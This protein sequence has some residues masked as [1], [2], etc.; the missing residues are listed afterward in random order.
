M[1]D[2]NDPPIPPGAPALSSD[3]PP[4]AQTA[5][6][7]STSLMD[8]LAKFG[9]DKTDLETRIEALLSAYPDL[10]GPVGPLLE[11]VKNAFTENV[12]VNMAQE[13]VAELVSVLKTRK[14]PAD[15]NDV[16]L[17]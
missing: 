1:T 7:L 11:A 2:P 4:Q 13:V 16:D 3:A 5:F 14:A 9:L 10:N 15:F 8:L 17:A 6:Q 12:V